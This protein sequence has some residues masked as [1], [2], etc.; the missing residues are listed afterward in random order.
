MDGVEQPLNASLLEIRDDRLL[1]LD[2]GNTEDLFT[3]DAKLSV[4]TFVR[5]CVLQAKD[6][7]VLGGRVAERSGSNPGGWLALRGH[8]AQ[9]FF[10][11][12]TPLAVAALA[13]S[14]VYPPS[15]GAVGRFRVANWSG[16]EPTL[17]LRDASCWRRGEN[18]GD[19]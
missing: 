16:A 18:D 19:R 17:V 2:P 5:G 13:A 9:D 12:E 10:A 1:A 7:A 3:T 14:Q 4:P 8:G 6:R 11:D 15:F